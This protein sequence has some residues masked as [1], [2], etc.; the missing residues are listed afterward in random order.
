MVFAFFFVG[1][2]CA[3]TEPFTLPRNLK[4]YIRTDYYI[5]SLSA[6]TKTVMIQ[7]HNRIKVK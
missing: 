4:T 2:M 6:R 3:Q 1:N 5:S 7:N